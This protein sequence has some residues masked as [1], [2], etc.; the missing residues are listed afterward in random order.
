MIDP[1]LVR[2]GHR[3]MNLRYLI[4]SEDADLEPDPKTLRPGTV[5]VKLD[6]GE[7]YDLSGTDAAAWREFMCDYARVI[8]PRVPVVSSADDLDRGP[9]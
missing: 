3:V 5:R 2:V 6:P 8:R 1:M 4:V 9:C 7:V